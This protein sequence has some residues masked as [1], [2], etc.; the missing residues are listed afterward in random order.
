MPA[1]R[2]YYP[3]ILEENQK[4]HLKDQEHHHLVN[5]M[6]IRVGEAI[7]I[8]NGKG[9]LAEAVLESIEKKNS[10]LFVKS[11]QTASPPSHHLILA[12]GMPRLNRLELI[13]EKGTELGMTEIWLFPAMRSEKK[14]FS[15]NQLERL[16]T[17]MIAA[18]KQCGRLFLPKMVIMPPLKQWKDLAIKPI[19][20]GDTNPEALAF[21]SV[22]NQLK[23]S[24]G[25]IF[26]IGPESGLTDE[27]V[28]LLQK[29]DAH[30]VK[31]HS[32]ILRTE[33]AAIVS[34]ALMSHLLTSSSE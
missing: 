6:R 24:N 25:A 15:E 5:V 19:F 10:S 23:P 8:I 7:E 16:N 11:V 29:L 9:Q 2:F 17:L 12:Q 22:W 13:V 32:N 27:E 26:C 21:M 3:E 30:G 4:I 1:E 33:T 31:L 18:M 34:L 14:D 20:F 28:I